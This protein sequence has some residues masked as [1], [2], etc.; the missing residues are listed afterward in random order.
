MLVYA[1]VFPVVYFTGQRWLKA[2]R[3]RYLVAREGYVEHFPGPYPL[4]RMWFIAVAAAVIVLAQVVFRPLPDY[5]VT[6]FTG[7]ASGALAVVCGRGTRFYFSGLVM[8]AL[9]LGVALARMP[10][11][12]R[13]PRPLWRDGGAGTGDGRRLAGSVHV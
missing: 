9:G 3:R 8:A 4:R 13:I 2:F 7:L 6:G 1:L 5:W 11:A 12:A 10:D